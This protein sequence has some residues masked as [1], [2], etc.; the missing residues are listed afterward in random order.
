[1]PGTKAIT[2]AEP[3]L[4]VT[5]QDLVIY[6]DLILGRSVADT[7]EAT[8]LSRAYIFN[9]RKRLRKFLRKNYDASR[10]RERMAG[11]APLVVKSLIYHLANYDKEIT[12][13]LADNLGLLRESNELPEDNRGGTTIHGD[14]N[15]Y[16]GAES[17]EQSAVQDDNLSAILGRAAQGSRFSLSDN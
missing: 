3:T 14:V 17:G 1:V 2:K 16:T 6:E 10:L 5:N 11:L 15:V 8:G 12:L 13:R 7:I 9:R 4:D